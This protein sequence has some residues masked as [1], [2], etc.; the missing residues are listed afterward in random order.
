MKKFL[1]AALLMFTFN[2][3]A[4]AEQLIA[5]VCW[6]GNEC[7]KEYLISSVRNNDKAVVRVRDV[8]INDGN[9]SGTKSEKLTISCKAKPPYDHNHAVEYT[10]WMFICNGQKTEWSPK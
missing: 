3:V 8:A 10:R 4:L 5:H 1:F 6:M 9:I 7:I 2:H